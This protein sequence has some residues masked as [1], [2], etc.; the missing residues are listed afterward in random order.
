MREAASR[1]SPAQQRD[2]RRLPR[3]NQQPK[4]YLRCCAVRSRSRRSQSIL[5]PRS[6]AA[7]GSETRR[8]ATAPRK[9]WAT[10]P[11]RP[12][13]L[14]RL[15]NHQIITMQPMRPLSE[16]YTHSMNFVWRYL[17][18]PDTG[19]QRPM[20]RPPISNLLRACSQGDP[21]DE[22]PLPKC[23]IRDNVLTERDKQLLPSFAEP[24]RWHSRDAWSLETPRLG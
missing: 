21:V 20:V 6:L 5:R 15:W 12:C 3:S 24:P 19:V 1:F 11:S 7:H 18:G 22:S 10:A 4:E 17:S 2:S 14:R 9:R 13:S 16:Q 23:L 8:T